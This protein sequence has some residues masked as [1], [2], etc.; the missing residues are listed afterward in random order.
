MDS[1]WSNRQ[2][3]LLGFPIRTSP[4]HCSVG[5]SPELFAATHVLHRLSAPRHPPHALS[6]L[7]TS[8]SLTETFCLTA[9]S[10]TL[11]LEIEA[12]APALRSGLE[13]RD[14]TLEIEFCIS[15]VCAF[16]RTGRAPRGGSTKSKSGA[17]RDRTD[18]PQLAKLV[19]SQLSYSPKRLR[20]QWAWVDSNHRP[21]AYQAYALTT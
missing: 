5:N 6:S 4:D 18:D 13:T 10:H 15:F 8:I 1:E 9:E 14:Y 12:Q 19:L 7:L 11:E 21:Y 20:P 2:L 17:D 16:Q 3:R